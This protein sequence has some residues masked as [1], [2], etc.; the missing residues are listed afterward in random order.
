MGVGQV[1]T[2]EQ[3]TPSGARGTPFSH[4]ALFYEG[5]DG[6]LAGTVPFVE[7]GL[8]AGEPALVATS[9][10]RLRAM[11]AVLGPAAR[12]LVRYV[13]MPDLGRNPAWIIPAWLDF[14][15]PH[16]REG[17]QVRGIGEPIWPER[18][19]DELVEC[20][21]HETLLNVALADATGF[22]L[23]CPYDV[24]SLGAD[25]LAD[26]GRSHPHVCHEGVVSASADYRD[27]LPTQL[28]D[29][30]PSPP[31]EAEIA[32]FDRASAWAVRHR[33]AAVAAAAGLDAERLEDLAVSVSEALTNSVEHGGGCGEIAWWSEPDRFLC[34]IRDHGTI[35]DPLVGRIRPDTCGGSGRGMWLIH[36]LCDLVQIR[37]L[38]DGTNVIRL[39]LSN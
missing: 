25:V 37:R 18:T 1:S 24:G 38:G 39:T 21:R 19:T 9:R 17:R 33:I 8:D 4:T 31:P 34:E 12:Q 22:S 32:T 13:P 20:H 7:A 2:R 5:D 28:T 27:T 15:T 30:L 14:V 11:D 16:V 36:Q 3:T 26:A 35:D 6:F 29:P 23:L 10:P